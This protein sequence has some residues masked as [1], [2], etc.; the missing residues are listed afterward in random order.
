MK[1]KV[2]YFCGDQSP[3]GRCHLLPLLNSNFFEVVAVVI[4]TKERWQIFR[5]A[6]SGTTKSSLSPTPKTLRM[7][8]GTIYN[9]LFGKA[10]KDFEALLK[11]SNKPLLI[12]HNVNDKDFLEKL[13]SFH[14]DL[15]IS[16]AYPQIFSND[17]INLPPSKCINFHPSL[18]PKYRGAHPHFWSIAKGERVSGLTAHF[19]TENI[20][21]GDIVA[22]IEYPI[23][24]LNY[25]QL[26]K[27]IVDET[28]ALVHQVE[29]F[30]K[31]K[32]HATPQDDS[33]ATYYWG[34]RELD[35]RI[36]WNRMSGEQIFNLIRTEQ[37]F[38]FFRNQK[39]ILS[40][41][42]LTEKNINLRNNPP[43]EPGTIVDLA[44]D[45]I[46]IKT[47]DYCLEV[48]RI[49]E[50]GQSSLVNSWAEIKVPIIG[51]KL[52]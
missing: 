34:D 21:E 7:R 44:D 20:D 8:L 42:I 49:I 33:R 31:K 41:A 11:N 5:K 35:K 4:P 24:E 37:A 3:Y 30:F 45:H 40:D 47:K 32:L 2:I 23:F 12:R 17:L 43:V 36:F 13:H 9:G 38:C 51:E 28:P 26:Y 6:L 52:H 22:Q 19:M 29:D 16:A 1:K 48:K 15:F 46:V 27:K 18:L 10:Q 25:T 50:S 14:A 39:I